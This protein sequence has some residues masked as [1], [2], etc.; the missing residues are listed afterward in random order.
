[1]THAIS[2]T[3][4]CMFYV[5]AMHSSAPLTIQTSQQKSDAKCLQDYVDGLVH[6]CTN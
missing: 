1:M 6:D 4:E 5:T 2:S 3:N